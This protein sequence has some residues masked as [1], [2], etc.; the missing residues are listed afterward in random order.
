[1]TARAA[2]A[3]VEAPVRNEEAHFGGHR[4][5]PQPGGEVGAQVER[6]V[7]H[8]TAA[9]SPVSPGTTV[10]D[11]LPVLGTITYCYLEDYPQ[12]IQ[13]QLILVE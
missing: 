3:A 6:E 8:R 11:A 10:P 4:V 2:V 7:A 9:F 5:V 13:N 12:Y 1:M